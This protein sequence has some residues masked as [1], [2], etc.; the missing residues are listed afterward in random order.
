MTVPNECTDCQ[1]VLEPVV[2]DNS[3]LFYEEL[4]E[5]DVLDLQA[6]FRPYELDSNNDDYCNW[7]DEASDCY[8]DYA[9]VKQQYESLKRITIDSENDL[10]PA[11]RKLQLIEAISFRT[12]VEVPEYFKNWNLKYLEIRNATGDYSNLNGDSLTYISIDNSVPVFGINFNYSTVTEIRLRNITDSTFPNISDFVNLKILDMS[13][14]DVTDL[15]LNLSSLTKLETLNAYGNSFSSV[16]NV[17]LELDSVKSLTIADSNI[18]NLDIDLREMNSLIN[19]YLMNSPSIQS[20][21][22]SFCE[23]WNTGNY[24]SDENAGDYI[25]SFCGIKIY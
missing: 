1:F 4:T 7:N 2:E 10:V 3:T 19:V 24:R 12:S 18:V 15:P 6:A 20:M 17:F 22:E 23:S 21:S 8:D 16:P 14:N 9:W 11:L 13:Y 5:Q 25:A